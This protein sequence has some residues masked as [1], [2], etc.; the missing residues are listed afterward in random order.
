MDRIHRISV[1]KQFF[2]SVD[3]FIIIKICAYQKKLKKKWDDG[4]S[5]THRHDPSCSYGC[6]SAEIHWTGSWSTSLWHW[7]SWLRDMQMLFPL[8]W[9]QILD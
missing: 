7:G 1:R 8:V 4:I 9:I 3:S 6:D 2:F 5:S